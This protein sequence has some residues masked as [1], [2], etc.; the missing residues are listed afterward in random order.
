MT[1]HPSTAPAAPTRAPDAEPPEAPAHG[2]R[3]IAMAFVLGN[4]AVLAVFATVLATGHLD[5][6]GAHRPRPD[7]ERHR[8]AHELMRAN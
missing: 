2:M 8:R 3:P 1:D 4:A 6:G 5:A 7:D